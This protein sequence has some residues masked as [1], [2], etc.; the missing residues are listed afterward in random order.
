MKKLFVLFSVL[1]MA[2]VA[3][4]G[5]ILWGSADSNPGLTAG[6]GIVGTAY[7]VQLK[8][9]SITIASINS[10]LASNG[11]TAPGDT[12]RYAV[13]ATRSEYADD[14]GDYGAVDAGATQVDALV[15][16]TTVS[17]V[18]FFVEGDQI[19]VSDDIYSLLVGGVTDA[20]DPVSQSPN[21]LYISSSQDWYSTT[22]PEPTVLAL[23]ALGVAGLALK[24]KVA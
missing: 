15:A 19:R 12:S 24:R 18:A 3:H 17:L 13:L 14:D 9:S 20:G 10:Y 5:A 6:N 4:A 23:L 7:L 16:G 22:V 2:V 8:D 11:M 1:S 21:P